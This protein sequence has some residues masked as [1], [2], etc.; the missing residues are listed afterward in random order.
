[1]RRK[2]IALP[3]GLVL[4]AGLVDLAAVVMPWPDFNDLTLCFQFFISNFIL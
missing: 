4:I 2:E 3:I 1:L